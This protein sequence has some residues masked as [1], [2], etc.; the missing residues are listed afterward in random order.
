[1]KMMSYAELEVLRAWAN[2]ILAVE[3]ARV[4]TVEEMNGTISLLHKGGVTDD[5]PQD[6]WPVAMLNCT[7][8]LVMHVLNARLRGIV[9]KAGILEPGQSGETGQE[10]R[11]QSDQARMGYAGG[12]SSGEEGVQS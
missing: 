1:M 11:Y 9:E 5:K 4:M 6:W 3:K 8:Q 7:N 12:I 2:E 10:H